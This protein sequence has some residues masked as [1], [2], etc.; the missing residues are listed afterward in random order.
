M[1]KQETPI[2]N[3][4]RCDLAEF[5]G[6]PNWRNNVGM[7]TNPAGNKVRFGLCVGSS[8]V[9]GIHSVVITQE[10]VGKT[11]GVFVGCEVKTL[12]SEA[13]KE[14][15]IKFR[16]VINK[17]GGIGFIARSIDEAMKSISDWRKNIGADP[18]E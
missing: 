12:T 13:A 4:I 1:G 2:Q 15:Q 9:I 3:D 18:I 7:L 5:L 10:M 14:K 11:V 8:D 17:H 16:N 6:M